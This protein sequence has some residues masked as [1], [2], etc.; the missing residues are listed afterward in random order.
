MTVFPFFKIR[1]QTICATIGR[2]SSSASWQT[3]TRPANR[4]GRLHS[5]KTTTLLSS[6]ISNSRLLQQCFIKLLTTHWFDHWL[7]NFMEQHIKISTVELS[8]QTLR[9]C[10][11]HKSSVQETLVS[12][13]LPSNPHRAKS[14]IFLGAGVLACLRVSGVYMTLCLSDDQSTLLFCVSICL[15]TMFMRGSGRAWVEI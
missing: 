4:E 2:L 1:N 8:C 9:T 7:T 6:G 5:E 14:H 12:H 10:Q 15:L 13:C 11:R 3:L